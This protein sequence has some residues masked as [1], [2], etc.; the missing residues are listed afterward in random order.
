LEAEGSDFERV[1]I[2]TAMLAIEEKPVYEQRMKL[3]SNEQI[4]F[5]MAYECF[6]MWS[7]NRG[8]EPVLK[9]REIESA[10]AA[11]QRHFSK[12]A[13]YRA[14]A[15]EKIWKQFQSC[16]AS[17]ME[18]FGFPSTAEMSIA[19][20]IAGCPFDVLKL[21]DIRFEMWVGVEFKQ[22]FEL[23]RQ[24]VQTVRAN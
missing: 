8:L 13:W 16:M 10:I 15:F 11:L 7:L 17:G 3:S 5:M 22:L 23:A 18:A 19:A 24:M 2:A 21:A 1:F 12:H 20:G 14:G 4:N 6:V 9:Q